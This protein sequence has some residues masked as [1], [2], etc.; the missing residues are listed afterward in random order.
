V[1]PDSPAEQGGLRAG[2]VLVEI[3]GHM[4][5]HVPDLMITLRSLSPGYEITA[6]VVRDDDPTTLTITL[7]GQDRPD[8]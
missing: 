8:S 4:I 5:G 6:T 3:D 2:D 7:G 1:T